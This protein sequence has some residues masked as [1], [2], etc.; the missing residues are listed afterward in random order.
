MTSS[1]HAPYSRYTGPNSLG[2]YSHDRAITL[3][4]FLAYFGMA[5]SGRDTYC[6]ADENHGLFLHASV[7][8]EHDRGHVVVVFLSSFPNCRHLPVV[9]AT[10][11]PAVWKTPEGAG[12]GS[13]KQDVLRM[14]GQPQFSYKVALK[15]G[16][17]EIAG[18]RD[19]DHIQTDVGDSSYVYNCDDLCA[20]QF[21]FKN[22]KVIW[23][24]ISDSE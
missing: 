17:D 24:S 16:P 4:S 20:T 23:I 6:I 21:E 18:M 15:P 3:K 12:I 9:T 13:T 2:I 7:D 8:D 1:Q 10:I 22:G 19:T 14:Y 11:D 5:P